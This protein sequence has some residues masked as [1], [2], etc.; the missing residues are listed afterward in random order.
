M[1]EKGGSGLVFYTDANY[2]DEQDGGGRGLIDPYACAMMPI[3]Y[4]YSDFD[5]KCSKEDDWDVDLAGYYSYGEGEGEEGGSREAWVA[6]GVPI[7]SSPT[8]PLAHRGGRQ[9]CPRPERHAGTRTTQRPWRGTVPFL[10]NR[11]V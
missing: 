2:W 5:E 9:G 1:W 4:C 10:E 8:H 3:S 7:L 6:K 11:A